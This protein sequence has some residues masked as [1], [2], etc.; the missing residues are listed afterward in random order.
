MS[1]PRPTGSNPE[2]IFHQENW[3]EIKGSQGQFNSSTTV[4]VKKGPRG[5]SWHARPGRGGSSSP[6][7]PDKTLKL[8]KMFGD[9]FLAKDTDGT[10]YQVAKSPLLR[11]S[12]LTAVFFGTT[13]TYTYP[14]NPISP[15]TP[16]T[17]PLAFIYRINATT[18]FSERA[19]VS[20][21]WEQDATI[22]A[23]QPGFATGVVSVPPDTTTPPLTPITWLDRNIDARAW[24]VLAD[25]SFGA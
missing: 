18:G 5:Y 23:Y 1:A 11:N 25:Q 10:I 8:Y 12:R 22:I 16:T 24:C 2:T 9:Y 14:H 17:D 4:K 15:A 3:D 13:W 6:P 20:P 7:T 19:I 21:P